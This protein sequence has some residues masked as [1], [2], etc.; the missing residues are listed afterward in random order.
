MDFKQEWIFEISDSSLTSPMKWGVVRKLSLILAGQS[1]DSVTLTKAAEQLFRAISKKMMRELRKEQ[2]AQAAKGS[3]LTAKRYTPEEF[4]ELMK[5]RQI[6]KQLYCNA[7]HMTT[8][9]FDRHI[10][11]GVAD[12]AIKYGETRRI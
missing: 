8:F 10:A 6:A 1:A 7:K 4:G 5:S 3:I 11:A 9:G 12:L 2:K